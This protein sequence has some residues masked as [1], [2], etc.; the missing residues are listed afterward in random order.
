MLDCQVAI[1]ENAIARYFASGDSPVPIG[2]RH[3][4]IIPF[5]AFK[6]KTD[7]I[8]IAVG[9]DKLWAKLC[10]LVGREELNQ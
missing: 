4:S 6:T 7:Y 5:E 8:I 10:T 9:N 1:L 2:N 3:P